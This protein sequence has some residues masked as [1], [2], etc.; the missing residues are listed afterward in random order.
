MGRSSHRV[1]YVEIR[2]AEGIV[3]N[4]LVLNRS[5][6]VVVPHVANAFVEE[7]DVPTVALPGQAHG[8]RVTGRVCHPQVGLSILR[9]PYGSVEV[10]AESA[11]DIETGLSFHIL[12]VGR[13]GQVIDG[14]VAVVRVGPRCRRVCYSHSVCPLRWSG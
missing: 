10:D 5:V 4:R 6:G 9:D 3:G 14:L 7:A 1:I 13:A 2:D 8:F 11:A 12:A